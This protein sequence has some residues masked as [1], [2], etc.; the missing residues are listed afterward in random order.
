LSSDI[1][2][3]NVLLDLP[4]T[5]KD[6]DLEKPLGG[7]INTPFS[8]I[9]IPSENQDHVM[10]DSSPNGNIE[11]LINQL[12]STEKWSQLGTGGDIKRNSGVYNLNSPWNKFIQMVSFREQRF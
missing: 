7:E 5:V 9:Y 3:F 6:Q 8:R 10:L 11:W 12:Q 1:H 2:T 4:L